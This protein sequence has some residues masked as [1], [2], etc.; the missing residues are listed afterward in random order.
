MA[1]P[2]IIGYDAKRIVRNGTGLGS[3]GRTL[4]NDLSALSEFDLRL[5][6]PDKGMPQ[7]R[8]QIVGR[9]N[10]SFCYP[11][12]AH[13]SAGKAL[14]RTK[15]I[16]KQLVRD[17]VDIYHGLSGELP[18]GISE[19]G[20]R[21]IVTIHDLIFMRH[22]E[23]YNK[24]DVKIY[25][26]KFQ[27]TLREAD[28]IVA[29]SEC[30]RRDISELGEIDASRIDVI[31]Q[32]CA[33]RFNEEPQA[34][35]MW[36][37]RDKYELPDRYVLNV[38]SIEERKNVMLAVKALHHLPDDVSL[39]IVG[40]QT[41]YSDEVHEYV[42]EHRMHGR[43][44]MLHNVPDDDLPALYRMAD[45]FVYPSRYEGFGIPIIEAISQGLPVVACTGS[46]LEEAGGPDSLYVG[47]DDPEAM[48]HAISRVLFG[49]PERQQRIDLSRQYIRRF[50]NS[51]AARHFAD[52]YQEV[53]AQQ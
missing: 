21:S 48:A 3:Y 49:A 10:V 46:C 7:L 32:S 36:Q 41:P 38:G 5:Y 24:M 27:Q 25:T 35:K 39:V 29:I 18:K 30:T 40:R 11:A 16:V 6:A 45:C 33:P 47:P 20:I 9:D 23:Y 4:V 42:L 53:L 8:S 28:R 22:P 50:E 44:Q 31:Y 34:R 19:S 37:V 12:N 14:W 17:E 26:R 15:G 52:L 43:V 13:T 51:D 2:T 1:K